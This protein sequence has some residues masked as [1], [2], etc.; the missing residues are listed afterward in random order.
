M[1]LPYYS[2]DALE[3]RHGFFTREGGVSKGIYA[4]LNCGLGTRDAKRDVRENRRRVASQ[5]GFGADR[6]VTLAQV[7]SQNVLFVKQ[8][9]VKIPE[10]DGMVSNT[11]GML[12]GILTADC[13]PVLFSDPVAQVVG[14]AHAGWKGALAGVI[15]NTISA[16]TALGG[17]QLNI[18]AAIGPCI[19][20]ASYEVGPEFKEKLVEA[21]A[22]NVQ[23]FAGVE[24]AGHF[25]FDLEA[26]VAFRLRGAGLRHIELCSMDTVTNEQ[27][28][29]SYRRKTL[30]GEPD[31]GRQLSVIGICR[32]QTTRSEA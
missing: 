5:L 8:P 14:A 26:Y 25:R 28:F 31:Y 21:N 11:P 16:M 15:E 22:A 29:F 9:Y 30:R 27:A 18:S 2:C 23:F 32:R 3:A 13:A 19:A 17:G 12:L 4:T 7:H 1:N 10:G 20:Q 24:K 6:L